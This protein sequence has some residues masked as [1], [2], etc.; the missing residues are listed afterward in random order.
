MKN[1]SLY[2]LAYVIIVLPVYAYDDLVID[3]ELNKKGSASQKMTEKKETVVME[4][5][6]VTATRYEK[7]R[8]EVPHM[9]TKLSRDEIRKQ[10]MPS[11]MVN[12]FKE[13]PSV[14]L[15]K[16]AHGQGSPFIRGFTG[17][18]NVFLIDGIRL[19]NSVF[20]AGPNQYWN[21]IDPYTIENFEILKG[22]A[23]VL[24]GS[25]AAGGSVQA[26]TRDLAEQKMEHGFLTRF[27]SAEDSV[28]GR[29]DVSYRL[30]PQMGFVGGF[31]K[32]R[33]GNLRT[34]ESRERLPYTGYDEWAMDFKFIYELDKQNKFT[35]AHQRFTQEDQ[36]RTHKTVFARSFR[37]TTIGN[38]KRRSLNQERDLSYLKYESSALEYVDDFSATLSLHNQEE[39]RFRI[40]ADDSQD[41]QGF[42][43]ST[44]GLLLQAKKTIA[45]HQLTFGLDYYNDD[46]DSFKN[47]YNANG[48]LKSVSIQGP[49]GDDS[50]YSTFE[51]F[52]QDEL[53]I[54]DQFELLAG[55]RYT[56]AEAAADKVEDPVTGNRTIVSKSWDDI[57]GSLRLVYYPQGDNSLSVFGGISQAFRA[58]NLSDLTRLDTARSNEI[59]TPSPNLDPES[60]LT[61]EVGTKY[62]IDRLSGEV[63]YYYTMVE[64]MITRTPTGVVIAGDDEVTKKNSGDGYVQG[65]EFGSRYKILPN[66]T[67]SSAFAWMD[68]EVDTYPTSAP[69][70]SKEVTDRLLPT[71]YQ[72]NLKWELQNFWVEGYTTIAQ[73][74]DKLST[75]DS[76]DTQRIPVGGTPGYAIFNLRGGVDLTEKLSLS[77]ALEN[78]TDKSYRVHGSGQNEAGFNS[79]FSLQAKF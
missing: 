46:V 44:L 59:E 22:P 76:K 34:G 19:N 33:F 14:L 4:D 45:T 16:T 28:A 52:I 32:K 12:V 53:I 62:S 51:L 24:Y 31:T 56:K 54:N 49:V 40:K 1:L 67:L 18:R 65:I 78:L 70:V 2:V 48:T 42:D 3:M 71:T 73:K 20:R 38:E 74:Q 57:V 27:S 25:D 58:P 6:V 9:I 10:K 7:N 72:F 63:S 41:L 21:T 47:K 15:Q 8:V 66:L 77:L 13:M 17:F 68:S 39:D 30:N 11:N 23:S 29:Y 36:W 69:V 50:E 37:G 61:F 5:V 64:D 79:I 35:L 55:A 75:R 60:F 43:V 26:L